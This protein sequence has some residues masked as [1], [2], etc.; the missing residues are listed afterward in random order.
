MK[1]IIFATGLLALVFTFS[2]CYTTKV[3]NGN[4]TFEQP[5]VKVQSEK[6]HILL[7]G[8]API[9]ANQK[10]ENFVGKKKDYVV[11]TQQTFVDGLLNII[12]FGIYSPNTTSYYLPIDYQ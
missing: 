2:S 1:K 11:Q 4:M 7:W 5:M 10:A 12:T 3:A 9:K 6:N 8:L